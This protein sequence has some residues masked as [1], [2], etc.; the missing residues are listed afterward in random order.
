M[1]Q[2][3]ASADGYEV[4][5][6]STCENE[7]EIRWDINRDGFQAYCP[8]CGSRLMLCD[9]CMQRTGEFVDDCNYN[10][11]KDKCGFSREPDWWKKKED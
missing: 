11:A 3:C 8:V 4:E 1:E 2:Y 5:Y 7:I 9:A 6:C 10:S